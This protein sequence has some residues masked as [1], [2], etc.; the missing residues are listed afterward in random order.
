LSFPD[1]VTRIRVEAPALR[2]RL[3]ANAPLAPYTWFRV[4]GPA[5]ALFQPVDEQDL[6][7]FLERTPVQIPVTVIGLGSNLI[8]RDGGIAGIVV[9]L[10]GKAFG[11][12]E[13]TAD[14]RV[15]AGSAAP[16][17]RVARAA[18]EAGV[19]GLEFYRGIPGSI[20][21]ALRMNAGA[22]GGETRETLIEA[23]GVDRLGIVRIFSAD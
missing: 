17:I 11:A 18:G 15:F 8:V 21:G 9:R 4:G 13:A 23:R 22:H 12:I 19:A 3:S 5:Q 20:G 1:I 16:D 7:Y 2:G 6:A 10:G 14:H